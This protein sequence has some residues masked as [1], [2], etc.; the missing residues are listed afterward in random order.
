M[1]LY[2]YRNLKACQDCEL[3][4]RVDL[5][6]KSPVTG[7]PVNQVACKFPVSRDVSKYLLASHLCDG[8]VTCPK[9]KSLITVDEC[10]L[11]SSHRGELRDDDRNLVKI[12][13]GQLVGRQCTYI[14]SGAKEVT[15]DGGSK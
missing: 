11:C 5:L 1:M 9:F 15:E 4:V 7:R 8:V 3:H 2:A 14:L 6:M 13:C 10:T 12:R